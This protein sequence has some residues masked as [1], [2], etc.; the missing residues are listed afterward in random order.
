MGTWRV[1]SHME[2]LSL[3]KH[4]CLISSDGLESNCIYNFW[5]HKC[6]CCAIS[7]C[8]ECVPVYEK[9]YYVLSW[10]EGFMVKHTHLSSN[11]QRAVFYCRKKFRWP[12]NTCE[13]SKWSNSVKEIKAV[14]SN[15]SWQTP[16]LFCKAATLLHMSVQGQPCQGCVKRLFIGVQLIS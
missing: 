8:P 7:Q 4:V 9:D 14:G 1:S 12:P 5:K 3:H 16:G 10:R 13:V 2:Y 11:W 15:L 6:T